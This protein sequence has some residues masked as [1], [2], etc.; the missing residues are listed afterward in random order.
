MANYKEYMLQDMDNKGK[1]RCIGLFELEE[2]PE[3]A[4]Q[5]GNIGSEVWNMSYDWQTWSKIVPI[6]SDIDF[7]DHDNKL[8]IEKHIKFYSRTIA[9]GWLSNFARYPQMINGILYKSN[10]H[11]YQSKKAKYP[12][13][14]KWIR[15]SPSAFLSMKAGRSL[16]EGKDLTPGWQELK[17]E[18]M[19][20]GLRAKFKHPMLRILLLK[21]G[22]RTL[23]EDSP[24]DMYWG[25][26]GQDMLG[27]LIMGIRDEIR[28]G[29]I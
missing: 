27:K 25:I 19:M 17:L 7:S 28:N 22:E 2:V 3:Q 14:E 5:K 24:T 23:H 1:I 11:Y 8:K 18:V 29:E 10:E 13:T 26:K 15:N 6:D 12:E 9:F 16:R 20:E 21:T 4:T